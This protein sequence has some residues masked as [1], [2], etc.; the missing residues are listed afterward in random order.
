VL[1]VLLF[2]AKWYGPGALAAGDV[3]T[4]KVDGWHGLLHLRWLIAVTILAA[5]VLGLV[6]GTGRLAAG[7]RVAGAAVLLLGLATLGWL[8]YRVLIS[9][10]PGQTAAAYVGLAC[11]VA[12]AAG[13][14]LTVLR[15]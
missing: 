4:G 10:P 12:I 7:A 2:A 5:L 3:L 9:I 13:G 15:R 1:L 8:G 6:W 14:G 11:A